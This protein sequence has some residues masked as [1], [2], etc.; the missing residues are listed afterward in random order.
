MDW[1]IIVS[2][3]DPNQ[4]ADMLG[5]AAKKKAMEALPFVRKALYDSGYYYTSWHAQAQETGTPIPASGK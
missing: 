2:S 5:L 3:Q 1:S 4:R